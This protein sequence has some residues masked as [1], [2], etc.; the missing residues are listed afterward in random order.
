MRNQKKK[1][2]L[3]CLFTLSLTLGVFSTAVAEQRAEAYVGSWNGSPCSITINWSNYS[4]LGA[5]SGELQITGQTK[6]YFFTGNNPKSGHLDIT[7]PGDPVYKFAKSTSGSTVKWTSGGISFSRKSSGSGLPGGGSSL[8]GG[9][10]GLPGG[11]SGLPGSGKKDPKTTVYNGTWGGSGISVTINW[12][13]YSGQGPVSGSIDYKGSNYPF[14]G[15]N[16]SKGKMKITIPTVGDYNM[17]KNG[18]GSKAVWS[19]TYGGTLL[20]FGRSFTTS[21]G[22]GLPGG[23]GTGTPGVVGLWIIACEANKSKKSAEEDAAIW[24]TKSFS[25]A[26]VLHKSHYSSLKKGDQD[27]W[28]TYPASGTKSSMQAILPQVKAIHPSAYGIKVDQSGNRE[29]FH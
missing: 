14:T 19:G 1:A 26:G 23:S 20:T 18:T 3:L 22:S 12:D 6:I 16:H 25:G 27:W 17:T 24:K 28:V 4:G 2:N 5:I 7:I 29:E 15:N 13:D 11:G 21:T 10:S 9:G 8:P